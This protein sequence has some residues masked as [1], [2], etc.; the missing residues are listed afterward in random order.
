MA[1]GLIFIIGV[2]VGIYVTSQIKEHVS[3]SINR[4]NFNKNLKEYDKKKK[5]EQQKP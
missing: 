3:S 1:H 2:V 5:A 4:K